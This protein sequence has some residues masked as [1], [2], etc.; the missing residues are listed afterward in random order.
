MIPVAELRRFA[1]PHAYAQGIP[2]DVVHRVMRNRNEDAK[3]EGPCVWTHE[4]SSLA[5][6]AE[7]RG[8]DL[9]AVRYYT[10]ARFPYVDGPSR[11]AAQSAGVEA[12]DRWRKRVRGISRL[13]L[14]FDG[15]GFACWAAGLSQRSSLPLILVLGGVT[16]T[17]EQWAPVL[18]GA[19]RLGAAVVV[20]ELPGVGENTLTYGSDSTRMLTYL[21]DLLGRAADASRTCVVGLSFGGHLALR[22]ALEDDRIRG[23][24]TAGAPVRDFFTRA[25]HRTPL[26]R[27][28]TLT[29]SHVMRTPVDRLPAAL[30]DWGVDEERLTRLR[31]PVAYAAS[32]D[33]EVAPPSDVRLLEQTVPHLRLVENDTL[34][35]R[36]DQAAETR[37]WLLSQ[38][39]RMAGTARGVR[40]AAS[41]RARVLRARRR[42]A[43]TLPGAPA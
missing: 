5:K 41:A 23:L 36:P 19:D 8:R 20:T 39:L 3:G 30:A 1:L 4:W 17:K 16:S 22:H 26:P 15:A 27:L 28:M 10:M 25:A 31:T 7:A 35:G 13:D 14:P 24:A 11:Q 9:D 43:R 32:R 18:A 29:L 2:G 6:A 38:A 40:R 34:G 33:D 42:L 21:L 12:F 37:L